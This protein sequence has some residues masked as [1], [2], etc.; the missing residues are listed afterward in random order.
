MDQENTEKSKYDVN[1]VMSSLPD[2]EEKVHAIQLDIGR[3]VREFPT[4]E[5]LKIVVAAKGSSVKIL[6]FETLDKSGSNIE[7]VEKSLVNYTIL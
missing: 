3:M 6:G 5:T 1:E 7:K 4:L 2:F